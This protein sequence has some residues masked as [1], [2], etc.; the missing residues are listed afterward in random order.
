MTEDDREARERRAEELRR[1]SEEF[2]SDEESGRP[3]GSPHEFIE[4][5]M[6]DRDERD[7][8]DDDSDDSDEGDDDDRGHGDGGGDDARG[9]DLG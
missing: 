1:L 2:A 9:G 3:P 8:L 7:G 4:R 6:R 5:E